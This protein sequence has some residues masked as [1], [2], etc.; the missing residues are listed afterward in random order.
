MWGH[1]MFKRK[2]VILFT[3]LLLVCVKL[4][5]AQDNLQR[6]YL[7]P[8]YKGQI[9]GYSDWTIPAEAWAE[10]TNCYIDEQGKLLMRPG[11]YNW[12]NPVATTL[13]IEGATLYKYWNETGFDSRVVYQGLNRI[14][15][16][17]TGE[18]AAGGGNNIRI[19]PL[20]ATGYQNESYFNNDG[21]P[22][23]STYYNDLFMAN[24]YDGT[25]QYN[26]SNDLIAELGRSFCI[27]SVEF[28]DTNVI[29]IVKITGD[30]VNVEGSDYTYSTG[31]YW[32]H[33]RPGMDLVI[34]D[35]NNDGTYE[36]V[37]ADANLITVSTSTG[38]QSIWTIAQADSNVSLYAYGYPDD[39]STTRSVTVTYV[40]SDS[41][42]FD[43]ATR[44]ICDYP[45]VWSYE[46]FV[47][48]MSL[49]VSGSSSNDGTYIIED[50][51]YG[52]YWCLLL[53][54][55]AVLTSETDTSTITFT[56]SET[57]SNGQDCFNPVA[58]TGHKGRLFA[59]GI[60]QYPTKLYW[61][62][63]RL[64]DQ[65]YWDLWR[66]AYGEDEGTGYIDV[67]DKITALVG[68]FRQIL[69]IFCENSILYLKGDDPGFDILTPAQSI[70]FY[71]IPISQN[72]G[73]VGPNAWCEAEGDIYFYSKEGLRK[74]SIV[75][76]GG[77]AQ[78]TILSLPIKDLHDDIMG[79]KLEKTIDLEYLKALNM[80]LINVSIGY[81]ENIV[82]AYNLANGAF[83]KWTFTDGSEPTSLFIAPGPDLDPNSD[84]PSET[85]KPNETVWFSSWDGKLWAM[86]QAYTYDRDWSAGSGSEHSISMTAIT[87]K[88]NMGQIFLEKTFQRTVFLCSPQIN[89]STSSQGAVTF[90]RKVD[91]G[92][93]SSGTS[94][95]FTQHSDTAGTAI[96]YY[97]YLDAGVSFKGTG[98]TIQYKIITSGTTG[99]FGLEFV[100][101]MVE[102]LPMDYRI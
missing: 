69:I 88:L 76:S 50:V 51:G 34:A 87:S 31:H 36:I 2:K 84:Y 48:G 97:E 45:V 25:I 44:M 8:P 4:V 100:G 95:S 32:L 80:I 17:I 94:K 77:A 42:T 73:C 64:R 24:G 54:P 33:F 62:Q 49:T 70:V 79:N 47:D 28:Q 6:Y 85:A 7:M 56:G 39:L 71:P 26:G 96:D 90:Y 27:A 20:M 22:S 89:Y 5:F 14:Y 63:S 11:F 66:D 72:I 92:A 1:N 82:I 98:K 78:F 65:Y 52:G 43:S 91:D 59:G 12:I 46:G 60:P 102:W 29:E 81:E 10:L 16:T 55:N 68:E 15:K 35:S 61:S 75:E 67:R 9:S 99:R 40:N 53:D 83:S 13:P 41:V 21:V 38:T 19:S 74:L 101:T 37:E 30:T 57:V 3:I 93:W 86:N 23:W 58:L 18:T